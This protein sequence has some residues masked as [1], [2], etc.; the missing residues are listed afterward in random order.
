M[1][2]II[3][4]FFKNTPLVD[5]LAVITGI[6]YVILAAKNQ[7]SCWAFGI[8]SSALTM[9]SVWFNYNL[10][11]ETFLNGFYILSGIWGWYNWHIQLRKNKEESELKL[12][13]DTK[14]DSGIISLK[15]K[16]HL[17]IVG[18]GFVLVFVFGYFFDVYTSAAATYPDAFVTVFALVATMMIGYR[19]LENWF[20]WIVIDSTSIF[21]YNLRGGHFYVL[22]FTVYIIVSVM[23]YFKWRKEYK[24]RK[25]SLTL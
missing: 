1:L 12:D 11:M 16:I 8:T 22:L 23:G 4:D 9:Y 3:I 6:V 2:N 7:I 14:K 21:L 10:Y 18:G 24:S 17:A 13:S 15:P 19:V 5:I 20:Y 25:H